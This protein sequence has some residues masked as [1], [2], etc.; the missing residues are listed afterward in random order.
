METKLLLQHF[1]EHIKN[2][3]NSDTALPA[4][5]FHPWKEGLTFVINI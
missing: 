5:G 1:S 2:I 4:G 3:Q